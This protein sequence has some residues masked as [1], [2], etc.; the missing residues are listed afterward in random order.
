MM[1]L[2]TFLV[3]SSVSSILFQMFAC[4]DLEDGKNYLRADYRVE[5]DSSQ[6]SRFRFTP[7]S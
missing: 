2:L 3:Y 4:D 5:C 6:H 1:L 7:A